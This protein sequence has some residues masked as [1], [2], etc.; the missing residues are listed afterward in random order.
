M[1]NNNK[2]NNNNNKE[3][4]IDNNDHKNIF[5]FKNNYNFNNLSKTCKNIYN[6]NSK[7]ITNLLQKNRKNYKRKILYY[8]I[9]I[10]LCLFFTINFFSN[11][12]NK[13]N[14]EIQ[15]FNN[16]NIDNYNNNNDKEIDK[17]YYNHND[18]N[19]NK[20]KNEMGSFGKLI[21]YFLKDNYNF[22]LNSD[23][24][25]NL[26]TI[27]S[28]FNLNEEEKE[29]EN[30][31]YNQNKNNNNTYSYYY[32]KY[33]NIFSF[34]NISF[35]S[36][37][38]IFNFKYLKEI[39]FSI[40][41]GKDKYN[42]KDNDNHN[43]ED[44]EK[45]KSPKTKIEISFKNFLQK[46]IFL[47]CKDINLSKE[48]EAYYEFL[49]YRKEIKSHLKFGKFLIDSKKIKKKFQEENKICFFEDIDEMGFKSEGLFFPKCIS[50]V[51]FL[52][53][54]K[55]KTFEKSKNYHK[56][57]NSSLNKDKNKDNKIKIDLDMDNDNDNI[58]Q[59]KEKINTI[60][61]FIY[62]YR[63]EN[64]KI[65]LKF[66]QL[67]KINFYHLNLDL[68]LNSSFIDYKVDN[69]FVENFI[70]YKNDKDN[71]NNQKNLKICN[72]DNNINKGNKID[73]DNNH[74]EGVWIE[75]KS[76]TIKSNKIFEN[77]VE[78]CF[79]DLLFYK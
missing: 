46:L 78:F 79:D 9:L 21:S 11:N 66:N 12:K 29:K 60:E 48:I 52:V 18:N 75:F 25:T 37:T 74:F 31:F 3:I 54:N 19:K 28:N 36:F 20:N 14:K 42:D 4:F 23:T 45:I 43:D 51:N 49:L 50:F 5:D 70:I 17:D 32:N 57:K 44:K 6:N 76:S 13:I 68:N 64:E 59:F 35:S 16:D 7:F 41:L 40:F 61:L 47:E 63:E 10:A 34:T 26:K 62:L 72:L 2:N 55:K 67:I 33:S 53:K 8:L 73:N 58:K 1:N 30:G 69:N 77:K 56:N 15:N 27:K 71:N 65:I 22:N 38:E 39:F 24:N